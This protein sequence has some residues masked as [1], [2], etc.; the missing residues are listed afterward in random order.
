MKKIL[1]T[2]AILIVVLIATFLMNANFRNLIINLGS[3][4]SSQEILSQ[5]GYNT[6][7]S[8]NITHTIPSFKQEDAK[9]INDYILT[10]VNS[11]TSESIYLVHIKNRNF[12]LSLQDELHIPGNSVKHISFQIFIPSKRITSANKIELVEIE[13]IDKNNPKIKIQKQVAFILK[14]P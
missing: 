8:V 13:I 3:S 7:P 14:K 4:T 6:P 1:L 5:V 2:L 10:I 11:N 9:I 12:T